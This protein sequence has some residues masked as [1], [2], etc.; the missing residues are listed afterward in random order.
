MLT[1]KKNLLAL[2]AAATIATPA[3]AD[4][5]YR[6]YEQNRSQYISHDQAAEAALKAVGKNGRVMEVEFDHDWH[7]DHFDVEVLAEGREYDV[8]VDAKTGKVLSSRLDY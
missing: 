3:L 5:D 2:M 1:L 8:I 4:D 6:Y 7:G